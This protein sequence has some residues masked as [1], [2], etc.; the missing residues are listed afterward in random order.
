MPSRTL[1]DAALIR[2]RPAT[3]A[4]GGPTFDGFIIQHTKWPIEFWWTIA[5]QGV[6]LI[7]C[8]FFLEETAPENRHGKS[9][10]WV[11][12]RF[13]TFFAGTR[14]VTKKSVSEVVRDRR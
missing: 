9:R 4:V 10:S 1:L 2:T 3:G 7:L 5:F 8:F 12:K 14:V 11:G 13:T 6:V